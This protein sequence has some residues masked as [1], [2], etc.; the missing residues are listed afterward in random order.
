MYLVI[1]YYTNSFRSLH[2]TSSFLDPNNNENIPPLDEP[3]LAGAEFIFWLYSVFADLSSKPA[4][5]K[6]LPRIPFGGGDWV[7]R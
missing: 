5:L 7:G 1:I 2:C 6:R 4:S 3:G